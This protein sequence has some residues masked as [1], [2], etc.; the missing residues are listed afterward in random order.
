MRKWR[1]WPFVVGGVVLVLVLIVAGV[2]FARG[3]D[4]HAAADRDAA[5][6]A[7]VTNADLGGT[8]K[9]VEHRSFARSRGGVR[10]DGGFSECSSS[11]SALE[12]DGQA[13]VDSIL[14]A[15]TGLSAQVVAEE[16]I[17]MGSS[18]SATPLVDAITSSARGCV[19]A[20]V[21]ANGENSGLSVA[22]QPSEA[23][24]VGD[25]ASAFHGSM[26][27]A[28]GR[29]AADVDLVV[30]QQGRAVVLLLVV[31]TTGSMHGARI[32]AML[33]KTLIRLVPRFGT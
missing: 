16:I 5:Q 33:N 24:S 13:V 30:V 32:E 8:F 10:V 17:A 19:T 20:A 11:D 7:L 23:P 15:Q 18:D 21:N 4:P 27:I 26:G 22:L 9:E 3:T 2:G 12:A 29:L 1:V 6:S 31:D 14:Q 28:N 25:R